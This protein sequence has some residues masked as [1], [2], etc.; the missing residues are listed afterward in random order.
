MIL[1]DYQGTGRLWETWSSLWW[2][3]WSPSSPSSSSSSSSS[4]SLLSLAC[5]SLVAGNIKKSPLT[6]WVKKQLVPIVLCISAYEFLKTFRISFSQVHLWWPRWHL[7]RLH[8]WW[9]HSHE[10]RHLPCSDHD[11]LSGLEIDLAIYCF[12]LH[13]FITANNNIQEMLRIVLRWR[14]F[15]IVAL[16]YQILTGEDWNEV[17]YNGIRSQGGVKSGMWSSIYFI[18]L[19]LFGNCILYYYSFNWKYQN[20]KES[21]Q[22]VSYH[23]C[24]LYA[25]FEV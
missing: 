21:Y 12:L 17:M 3:P 15:V 22:G 6:L 7:C 1:R 5:S 11:C 20:T 8:L 13:T 14:V 23:V 18:V 9:L 19:T 25:Y 4:L 10:L 16:F 24:M 2:T